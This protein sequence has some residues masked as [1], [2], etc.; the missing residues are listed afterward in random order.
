MTRLRHSMSFFAQY[1]LT[2]RMNLATISGSVVFR[3]GIESLLA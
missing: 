2:V 3:N 1:D